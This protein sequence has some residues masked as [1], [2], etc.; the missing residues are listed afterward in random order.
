MTTK[1][2]PRRQ[3]DATTGVMLIQWY[4]GHMTKAR[5]ELGFTPKWDIRG[6]IEDFL[7]L[8]PPARETGAST[9]A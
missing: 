5:R 4:P 1:I 6:T 2:R 7:G 3:G 9:G 8:A